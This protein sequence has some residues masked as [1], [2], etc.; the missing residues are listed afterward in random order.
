MCHVSLSDKIPGLNLGNGDGAFGTHFNASL[1]S[2]AFVDVHGVGFAVHHFQNT[3]RTG[4]DAFLIA[5]AFVFVDI[6]LP[7][8]E[9]SIQK[10]IKLTRSTWFNLSICQPLFLFEKNDYHPL[11]HRIFFVNKKDVLKTTASTR[12]AFNNFKKLHVL[13]K[14]TKDSQPDTS[15][16][17]N[18]QQIS[19]GTDAFLPKR[20]RKMQ[21]LQATPFPTLTTSLD[22]K[23]NECFPAPCPGAFP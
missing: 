16:N 3:C 15:Q 13:N 7:H 20:L 5:G 8:N 14:L 1:A 18:R 2:E 4:V 6:Y 12:M 23:A 10:I 9:T 21:P 22:K 17:D 19:R 11:M